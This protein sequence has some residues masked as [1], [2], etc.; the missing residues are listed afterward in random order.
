M[1]SV[2]SKLKKMCVNKAVWPFLGLGLA[3]QAPVN[4]IGGTLKYW[5]RTEGVDLG[6]IGLFGLVLIPYTLKF[7]WAPFIDRINLPFATRFG[8][9]KMWGLLIQLVLMFCLFLLSLSNPVHNLTGVFAVC[10]MIAFAS[11]T[12]DIVIDALRIDTLSGD[13]LKEG[14]SAYQLG[15]RIG[16]LG[17]VAGMIFLSAYVS[18]KTAYQIS[19]LAILLGF[20]S[21]CFVREKKAEIKPVNFQELVIAP[22]K[23]FVLRHRHF[24]LLC[25]FVVSYKLCNGVLGP[26]AYPFYYDIGFTAEQIS[27]VSGTFGVFITML[28]V[29][30]G[31][32]IMLKYDYRF[33]LFRLGFIEIFTSFAFAE[34]ALAGPNLPLFFAVILFDNILAGMGGAVWVAYLS[35]LCN[36]QFSGTQY[37]FLTALNMIPLSIIASSGGFWAQYLGWPMFFVFTGLLMIPALGIL[38]YCPQLFSEKE[39]K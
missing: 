15:A 13:E 20:A 19:I 22:F 2:L 14:T 24:G 33:L 27:I 30:L 4:L 23:D 8:R 9:K 12:Q 29:V 37:A 28:G 36:R 3:S 10:L 7:L 6:Q 18:W 5:F 38:K 25:L 17:A 1:T 21:L 31:G 26:M 32:L 35:T 39:C 34:L 11:A 16:M